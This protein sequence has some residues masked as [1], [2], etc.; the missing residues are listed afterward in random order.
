MEKWFELRVVAPRDRHEE[1]SE[2]LT[3]LG[4]QAVVENMEYLQGY[5]DE[6]PVSEKVALTQYLDSLPS[7]FPFEVSVQELEPRNWVEEYKKY[8][9]AQNLGNS[10]F[11]RPLWDE[12]TPIPENRT[13]IFMEPGQAFGTGLHPTT[14]LCLSYLETCATELNFSEL[15]II[16]VGTG[17]GILAIV[18]HHLK[19]K[20]V[21]AMDN[22]PVAV[23]VAKENIEIN[24]CGG[25][26]V[27]TVPLDKLQCEFD[28]VIANILLEAHVEL[29]PQYCRI[30]RRGG[31]LMLSG[32]LL[33]HLEEIQSLFENAGL[34][35][36]AREESG[37]WGFMAFLKP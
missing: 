19:A 22:D 15:D 29:L 37:E 27:N 33:P 36:C 3:E 21:T 26:A 24:G 20:S 32:L 17:T 6:S 8:Y 23:E 30:L 34:K 35:L 31:R 25:M 13:P 16:D 5:F 14:Q 7:P 4:A 11:L 18:A 9:Q 12:K 1:I 2:K 28:I 10:F